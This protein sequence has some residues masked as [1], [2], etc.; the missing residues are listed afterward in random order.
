MLS[1]LFSVDSFVFMVRYV[2]SKRCY[3]LMLPAAAFSHMQRDPSWFKIMCF[4]LGTS[5]L[6]RRESGLSMFPFPAPIHHCFIIL[7]KVFPLAA[8]MPNFSDQPDIVTLARPSLHK[9][10]FQIVYQMASSNFQMDT[11]NP[12]QLCWFVGGPT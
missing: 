4:C 7:L 5:V 11:L 8:C 12:L 3:I 1:A 6:W 2:S 10:V 9:N